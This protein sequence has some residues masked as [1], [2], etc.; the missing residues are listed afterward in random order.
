MLPNTSVWKSKR[1]ELK[2]K[3]R[4]LF[5]DFE[6]CPSDV[7]LTLKIKAIDDDIA[8]CTEHINKENRLGYVTRK[9]GLSGT[10]WVT[11]R[12]SLEAA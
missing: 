7:V 8:V 12:D 4:P 6:K 3:R 5:R 11:R 2:K 1:E 10:S 9:D